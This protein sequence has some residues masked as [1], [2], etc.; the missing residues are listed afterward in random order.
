[1]RIVKTAKLKITSHT[2]L[3]GPTLAIYRKFLGCYIE[4]INEKWEMFD[5]LSASEAVKPAESMTH[6]TKN[7]PKP[8][9]EL[10]A[11]GTA[12]YKFPSYLRRAAIAEAHG[13]VSSHRSRLKSWQEKKAWAEHNNKKFF[14]HPPKLRIENEAFPVF[15][16]KEMLKDAVEDIKSKKAT[17]KIKLYVNH[18]WVWVEI[19]YSVRNFKSGQNLRFEN[20]DR[21]N[22]SLIQKGKKFFLHIPF[23]TNASLNSTSLQDQVVIGVD[24]GLTNSAVVS[25]VRPD[26]TVLGRR[27]INQPKEKDRLKRLLGKLAKAK[28]T[29]GISEKPN[30]WRRINGIQDYIVQNTV[31]EIIRFANKYGAT[32]IVMEHLG[33][34]S[35]PKGF[36][37]AKRLRFKLQFWSK[38]RI[39]DKLQAKAHEFGLRH[40]KVLARGT[41]MYAFDGSGLVER[42][43]K[44]D[45]STFSTGKRYHA[46]LSASYNI[47]SRYYLRELLKPLPKTA[48]LQAEAKVP[49]LAARTTHTLSSLIKL[50]EVLSTTAKLPEA[51]IQ[52]KEASS[53]VA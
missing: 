19:G 30:H 49:S 33:K 23:E 15:Y 48:R 36:Y 11:K 53:I 18:D 46:D 43:P 41:S 9:R 47:A 51:R 26:G 13:I 8:P 4:L 16:K 31:D 39:Q 25:A 10:D 44:K 20:M 3:F 29:S 38:L 14:E 5:G 28:R 52:D 45:M 27:F 50:H 35:I 7:N 22:A 12:F 24:L 6:A 42:S 21:K 17:A 37:G 1:M 2:D 34:M 40:S 32:Y